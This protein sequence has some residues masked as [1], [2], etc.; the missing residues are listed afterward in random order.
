MAEDHAVELF[1]HCHENARV[2]PTQHGYRVPP[3]CGWV[4]RAFDTRA[5]APS[6]VWSARLTGRSVLRT[7]IE[8]HLP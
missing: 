8:V 5:P 2:E 7:E 6:I 1:F 3:M 4:S